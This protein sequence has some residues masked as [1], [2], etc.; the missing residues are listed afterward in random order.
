MIARLR[1]IEYSRS[2]LYI[3][4]SG[5]NILIEYLFLQRA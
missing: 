2:S 4:I 3:R 1:I 5:F